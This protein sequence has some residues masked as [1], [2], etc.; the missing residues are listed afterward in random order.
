M[1]KTI[2]DRAIEMAEEY[3]EKIEAEMRNEQREESKKY[4]FYCIRSYEDLLNKIIWFVAKAEEKA[5]Q[6]QSDK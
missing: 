4:L 2:Y 3:I 6:N 1:T 5:K